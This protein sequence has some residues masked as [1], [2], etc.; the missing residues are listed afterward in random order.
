[1]TALLA[2]TDV[3]PW[4]DLLQNE[5]LANL[6]RALGEARIKRLRFVT[7]GQSL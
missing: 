7:A 1:M 2:A 4:L 3:T 5:L 6:N